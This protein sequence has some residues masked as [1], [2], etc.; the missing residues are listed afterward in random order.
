MAASPISRMGRQ[1]RSALESGL[2]SAL[3][4]DLVEAT[5]ASDSMER[6]LSAPGQ[7]PSTREL[8]PREL[9]EVPTDEI[10]QVAGAALALDP[11]LDLENLKRE[12]VT[13][14]GWSR[15][16]ER[17]SSILQPALVDLPY[18]DNS[19]G[20]AALDRVRDLA[21]RHGCAEAFS[22][23]VALSEDTPLGLKRWPN[24]ITLTPPGKPHT[25]VCY[26]A[27]LP[28]VLNVQMPKQRLI[29][30]LGMN[31]ATA[32]QLATEDNGEM[33]DLE[34]VTQLASALR[35]HLGSQ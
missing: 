8:G 30:L 33:L 21:E 4:R 32:A 17:A 23:M 6:V 1:V 29:D 18:R 15:M 20:D 7:E 26:I 14:Y 5:R 27:P 28:G 22:I 3:R 16:S 31:E 25:T 24:S 10:R 34:Q 19:G 13:R 35:A 12:V 11:E 2:T 9:A